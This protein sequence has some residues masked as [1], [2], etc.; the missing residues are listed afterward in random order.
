MKNMSDDDI[1]IGA[2]VAPLPDYMDEG[3]ARINRWPQQITEKHFAN[4]YLFKLNDST[5]WWG[6][7]GFYILDNTVQENE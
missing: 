7:A 6:T 5:G 2:L 1:V 4:K 3:W